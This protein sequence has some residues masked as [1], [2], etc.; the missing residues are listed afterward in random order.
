[1]CIDRVRLAGLALVA[2]FVVG[3]TA[4]TN[5][6][7]SVSK[8]SIP[9]LSAVSVK[10]PPAWD[11]DLRLAEAEDINP[12]PN[13]VEIELEARI[14]E[15]ELVPGTLTP[16]W[17]YGG[18][19]PGPLVRA[20]LGDRVI[21]HFK[22]SLPEA[23]SIHWHGLRISN[24]MDGVPGVTQDPVEAGGE[25]LYDFVVRDAGTFWYHPHINSAAQV[26]W[27]MYGPM[28]VEDPSDPDVFGEELV[29]LLSDMSLDEQGQF[30]PTDSGGKFGDLFGREGSVL[31]VNGKVQPRLKV[32]TGKQQRWRVINA[33][34]SRYYALRLPDHEFVHLG[35]DGGLAERATE[36]YRVQ[37]VP[38]ERAD[39][40]FTP[41]DPPGTERMLQWVPTERGFG[42][43]F[44][45]PREDMMHIE[46]VADAPVRPA[47]IPEVLRAIEPIDV[48]GA[49]EQTL[50][51][52]IDLSNND[53][54]MGINGIPY[55]NMKPLKARVGETHVWTLTNTSAFSHPFHLHGYF[56]QV[57][58]GERPREWKD[59]IDVPVDSEVKIAIEF[60]ERPGVWMYHCHILDHAEAGMMGQLRVDP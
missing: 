2:A 4:C 42:S 49:I 44:N 27:G 51:F 26:G 9:E 32:R 55:W 19:L 52:T 43:L 41:S 36:V 40:V 38:G 16:V 13:V 20:K 29:L 37:L 14:T 48:E 18:K 1:M 60:D 6:D 54:V 45:R 24:D 46:T 25:F 47:A 50:D 17:T 30:Q 59:T 57:L 28:I 33:A 3:A 11:E 5:P 56:F 34:R 35:G 31:L 58:N 21:V 15:M 22:N 10:Q 23:T 39:I 8:L 12:D 7:N 53:V